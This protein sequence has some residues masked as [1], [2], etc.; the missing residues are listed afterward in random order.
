M[1][2]LQELG[3]EGMPITWGCDA[4]LTLAREPYKEL[5]QSFLHI[6]RNAADHGIERPDERLKIGKSAAGSMHI[7]VRYS[8][9]FYT[10]T[11]EDDGAGIDPE[12]L[13]SAARLRGV[14]CSNS[15]T[16]ESALMLIYEPGF[17]SHIDI[18]EISGRGIGFSAVRR[19]ARLCGG[20]VSVESLVGR[21][22]TITV[23]FKRQRY[24]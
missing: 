11:F 23:S 8:D 16:P 6:V 24:W 2:T 13:I 7:D 12:S 15:M 4:E 1:K 3:K 14:P 5:F 9:G 21:G 22:T 10:V 17:S 18:T 20:D 19:A